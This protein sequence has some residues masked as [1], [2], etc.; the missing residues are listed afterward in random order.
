M[1]LTGETE[2][3]A[4]RQRVWGT[5]TDPRQVAVCVPGKP[6]VEIVDDRHMRVTALVGNG[7]FQTNLAVDI[8]LTDLQPPGRAT[9]AASSMIMG[10]PVAAEGRLDLSE[11][12]PTLTRVSWV[13]D[14]TLG[15]ILAS[16][17]AMAEA[18]VRQGVE[19]TL[20]NLKA[21]IEAAEAASTE[22]AAT[23]G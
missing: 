18:P 13:A 19:Q 12:G 10:G 22:G 21:K 9:A 6:K 14:V 16:F 8:V 4:S 15:G 3:G 5:L 1:H 2:I 17:A 20:A 23:Q 11:L 7:F